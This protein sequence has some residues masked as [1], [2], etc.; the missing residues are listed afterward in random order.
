MAV[1]L[2][3]LTAYFY[4]APVPISYHV[5]APTSSPASSPTPITALALGDSYSKRWKKSVAAGALPVLIFHSCA[6]FC[7]LHAL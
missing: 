6:S 3:I 1:G 4:A 2:V 7:F 5:P